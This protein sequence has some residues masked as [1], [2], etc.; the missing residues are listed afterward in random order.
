MESICVICGKRTYKDS[1]YCSAHNPV[2]QR[3]KRN[4]SIRFDYRGELLML[5]YGQSE[6]HDITD[7]ALFETVKS[8]LVEKSQLEREIRFMKNYGVVAERVTEL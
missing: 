1:E 4:E 3:R 6:R 2:R 8:L 7:E 5:F